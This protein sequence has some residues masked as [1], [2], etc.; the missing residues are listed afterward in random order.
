[1]RGIDIFLYFADERDK[2]TPMEVDQ[3]T[4]DEQTPGELTLSSISSDNLHNLL[5][6][7]KIIHICVLHN[8]Y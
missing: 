4:G 8:A 1:M 7:F 3:T 2:E 5:L 6:L